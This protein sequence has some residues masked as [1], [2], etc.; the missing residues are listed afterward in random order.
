MNK[1]SVKKYCFMRLV[2]LSGI[3]ICFSLSLWSQIGGRNAFEFLNLPSSA[4][5]TALGGYLPSVHDE[6]VTLAFGNPASLNSR[7]HNTLSFSHNF[8]FQGIQNGYVGYG[9]SIKSWD[10]ETHLGVQYIDYGDFVR[11]DVLGQ[12]DGFFDAGE[13]AFVIGA[14]KR[15]AERFSVGVNMKSI[16]SRAEQ[17]SSS[18]LAFDAGINYERDSSR[19]IIS[20]LIRNA[21]VEL[22]TFAGTRYG[23][24]LDVQIGFSRRLRYLPFRFSVI[25]HQLHIADVRYDDP[26]RRNEVDFLGQ[27]VQVNRFSQSIDNIFRHLI[28]NGEFLL[29]KNEN[30][31]LRV[32]Y[33]HLRRR[34]LSLTTF[35]SLAG[36]SFGAGIKAG[37]FR[38]DY[39]AGYHH[40]VG[41]V[42][43]VSISTDMG[44]FFKKL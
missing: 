38:L 13:T 19:T 17:Y 31:R 40:L 33:N 25:A 14:S 28:F 32:G 8:H 43:H 36:F 7:M 6:D 4:R 2:S 23:M 26:D 15:L 11:A 3:C 27:E 5:L 30:V 39:G 24:P 18:G 21:G 9:R 42:N 41:A 22:T 1:V 37:A 10:I 12:Q 44:K 20:L 29:G 16:F 34:E 35:R